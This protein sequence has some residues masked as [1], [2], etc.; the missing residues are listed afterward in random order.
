MP[1]TMDTNIPINMATTVHHKRME[2]RADL[3][4]FNTEKDDIRSDCRAD[5]RTER[6]WNRDG[7]CKPENIS[8]I[9]QTQRYC[10]VRCTV[11]IVAVMKLCGK[12]KFMPV[13]NLFR[14]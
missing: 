6:V 4:D 11:C 7:A 13:A 5:N 12:T 3:S 8:R 2:N 10:S 1:I 9:S 14:W